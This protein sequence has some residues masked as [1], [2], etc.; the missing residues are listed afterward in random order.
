MY[1]IV[2]Y[3]MGSLDE[4]VEVVRDAEHRI[5][6]LAAN[7]IE[8]GE[9]ELS[10]ALIGLA[11]SLAALPPAR[12]TASAAASTSERAYSVESV[13]PGAGRVAPGRTK[14]GQYP[15]FRKTGEMLVK[16]GWSRT[17]RSEY[18][19][20]APIRVLSQLVD[21]LAVSGRKARVFTLEELLPLTAEDGIEVPTYQAY[22]CLAWLR[23][24]DI[25]LQHGRRGYSILSEATLSRDVKAALQD[26]PNRT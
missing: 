20:R 16:T 24:K 3:V 12:D 14:R 17:G 22:L 10:E 8:A 18:E 23:S 1:Y 9:Y 15:R 4:A 25:V 7:A 5:R 13:A 19:H 6:K 11:S 26:L 21:R 2:L